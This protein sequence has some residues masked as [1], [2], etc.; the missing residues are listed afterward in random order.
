MRKQRQQLGL[1]TSVKQLFQRVLFG[2]ET[3]PVVAAMTKT[4]KPIATTHLALLRNQSFTVNPTEVVNDMIR[5]LQTLKVSPIAMMTLGLAMIGQASGQL[6][7]HDKNITFSA[8]DGGHYAYFWNSTFAE[9]NNAAQ[10]FIDGAAGVVVHTM[11]FT[12][13]NIFYNGTEQSTGNIIAMLEYFVGTPATK[14]EMDKIVA[15]V[16]PAISKINAGG[17]STLAIILSFVGLV[18]V[19]VSL[20]ACAHCLCKR[21]NSARTMQA[22][23]LADEDD[24]TEQ[25]FSSATTNKKATTAKPQYSYQQDSAALSFEDL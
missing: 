5:E 20:A 3:K 19:G 4:R 14:A 1:V 24:E 7:R 9:L 21:R 16:D 15:V 2:A 13:A 22:E 10:A 11:K 18:V 17:L 6:M 25:L 23:D 12:K 8:P